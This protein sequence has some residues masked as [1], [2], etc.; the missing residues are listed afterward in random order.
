MC[1]HLALEEGMNKTGKVKLFVVVLS[2]LQ[3]I[4]SI[5]HAKQPSAGQQ[6]A[7]QR[8]Q[9]GAAQA[10]PEP[11]NLQVLKGMTR[12]QVIQEMRN[13][14]AALGV[15]C[16]FCHVPPFEA[17]TPRKLTARLMARDYVMGMKHKDGSAVSCKDCH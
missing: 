12:A 7:P 16:N 2:V 3:G 13:W 11:K 6:P 10:Q 5:I 14:S 1:G 15:E 8:Q 4:T 17:D 9:P